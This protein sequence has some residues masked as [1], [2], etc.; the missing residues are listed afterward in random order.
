MPP[1]NSMGT[2]IFIGVVVGI[3]WFLSKII[4]FFG[5]PATVSAI[6][7]GSFAGMGYS[8]SYMT[9]ES[10]MKDSWELKREM[11]N[12]ER[13]MK[14]DMQETQRQQSM[15]MLRQRMQT[16]LHQQNLTQTGLGVVPVPQPLT[17]QPPP[18]QPGMTGADIP[19]VMPQ[20]PLPGEGPGDYSVSTHR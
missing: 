14:R 1:G 19:P 5:L 3:T 16:Q 20:Y 13:Q 4:S 11:K 17:E 18:S 7:I 9:Y 12:L 2:A 15:N 6:I 8:I 10:F